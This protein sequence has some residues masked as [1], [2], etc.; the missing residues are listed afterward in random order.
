MFFR[1]VSNYIMSA[2]FPWY[3][4][5][6][7]A[8]APEDEILDSKQKPWNF[9]MSHRS[10]GNETPA[11]YGNEMIFES[12]NI[13]NIFQPILK[14]LKV[15]SLI[16]VKCNMYLRTPEIIH[17]PSHIDFNY[18][19]KGALFSINTNNGATVLEDGTEI[20]SVANRLL[21]FDASKPHHSTTTSNAN[22]RVNVN[23][24]YF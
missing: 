17:S 5:D 20:K 2:G 6:S 12:P 15:K 14:L 22:R 7:I 9:Y 3:F 16:R 1:E 18:E 13:W 19:H 11:S 8:N 23:L 4:Q 24:N 10:Y 21:L